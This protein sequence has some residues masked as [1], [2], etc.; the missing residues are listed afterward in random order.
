MASLML[1]NPRKR[2]AKKRTTSKK[3]APARRL[4][5]SKTVTT[6]RYRRNPIR[7]ANSMVETVKL[8]AVGAGGA[9]AV[10]VAF[11]KLPMIPENLKTGA[12]G[13]VT[14][15]FLGIGIGMLVAKVGK[16]R[17]LGKQIADGAVIVS[18]YEA[19]KR[20]IG[21]QLGLADGE[22]LGDDS[23]LY[24][25]DTMSYYDDSSDMGWQDAAP[26]YDFDESDDF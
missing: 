9:L 5:T 16:N 20:A 18:M 11:S 22:L 14:K 7:T 1:V 10:D 13:S 25:D 2:R 17:K 19:A 8:G 26:V 4:A 12:V 21:P 3:R 24:Y 23:L 15:G 6:R